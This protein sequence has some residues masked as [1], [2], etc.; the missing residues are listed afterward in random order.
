MS[1]ATD[2]TN[3]KEATVG[4]VMRDEGGEFELEA[5]DDAAA[6]DALREGDW[7][8]VEETFWP[9]ANVFGPD[10]QLVG[11]V[12]VTIHPDEPECL[13]GCDDH[14][15]DDETTRGNGGGVIV[16]EVCSWCGLVRVTDT[17]ATDRV[18]GTQGHRLVRYDD[19]RDNVTQDYRVTLTDPLELDPTGTAWEDR[20]DVG[21]EE[22]ELEAILS[23]AG[24]AGV[25]TVLAP[26]EGD[27]TGTARVRMPKGAVEPLEEQHEVLLVQPLRV[28]A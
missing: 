20:D 18:D 1:H 14:T 11:R 7:N 25:G 23:A 5:G 17:W 15:W 27:P 2:N 22:A 6:L 24:L 12:R 19:R 26:R 16:R 21:A 28:L 13:P 3:T 9:T 4:Y 8:A 10:G